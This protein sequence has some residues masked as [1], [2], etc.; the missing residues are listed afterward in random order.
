MKKK[1]CTQCGKEIG[2]KEAHYASIDENSEV[3]WCEMC[4]KKNRTNYV[5]GPWANGAYAQ[6]RTYVYDD[7]PEMLNNEVLSKIHNYLKSLGYE[8]Y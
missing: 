6:R 8:N 2:Y 1:I 3:Y 5:D 7:D 4:Y